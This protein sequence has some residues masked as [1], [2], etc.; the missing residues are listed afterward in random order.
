MTDKK[1]M[2]NDGK[3]AVSTRMDEELLKELDA[4][5]KKYGFTKSGFIE[6]SVRKMIKEVE[7]DS[8][9]F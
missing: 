4:V 5:C 9:L 2:R 6:R 1:P 8:R 7:D 3:K